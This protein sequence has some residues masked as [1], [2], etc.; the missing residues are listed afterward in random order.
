MIDRSC[1]RCGK[2]FKVYLSEV[3][4]KY[5]S[6]E[7]RKAPVLTIKCINCGIEFK[8][9]KSTRTCCSF[10][11]A[12]SKAVHDKISKSNKGK[13][14]SEETKR[15]LSELYKGKTCIELYGKDKAADISEKISK[16][17]K[18]KKL[19][20]EAIRKRVAS[21]LKNNKKLTETQRKRMSDSH[22]GKKRSISSILKGIKT[23]FYNRKLL[24]KNTPN[25]FE[26]RVY[27]FLK[28]LNLGEFIFTGG[29]LVCINN[30]IPDFVNRELKLVV[31]CNGVYWH[32]VKS[33][34][35]ISDENKKTVELLESKPYLDW[36]Y[37]V[38]FV[39][40]KDESN[41]F[42]MRIY[43]PKVWDKNKFNHNYST[44][45]TKFRVYPPYTTETVDVPIRSF[46]IFCN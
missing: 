23:L 31:L 7:C 46:P 12:H 30:K 26:N 13:V 41:K 19:S 17:H 21:R 38:L 5:C 32:L 44:N 2:T 18:G 34:L 29:G 39:W 15:K 20:N 35:D 33:G 11:C 1:V 6:L 28:N 8:T 24:G 25:K 37:K 27:V 4:K 14:C 43:L 42:N 36:G 10:D 16:A 3:N 22:L 40:E 45:L 9:I